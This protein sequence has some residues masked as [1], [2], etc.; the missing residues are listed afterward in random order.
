MSSP[1]LCARKER[2][3]SNINTIDD[4]ID[5]IVYFIELNG[6]PEEDYDLSKMSYDEILQ[7]HKEFVENLPC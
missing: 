3:M 5:E 7:L 4:Y 6:L 1:S 2:S